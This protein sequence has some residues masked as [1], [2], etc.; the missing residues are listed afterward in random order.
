MS[1]LLLLNGAEFKKERYIFTVNQY[2]F[3]N[4]YFIYFTEAGVDNGK[5]KSIFQ[6]K[7]K[8]LLLYNFLLYS[9]QQEFP[10]IYSRKLLSLFCDLL[11]S[12]LGG[13]HVS[14]VIP[15]LELVIIAT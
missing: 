15:S 6:G 13:M 7:N 2:L 12:F 10:L 3:V 4:I 14:S 9:F 5:M 1:A 8:F 11:T